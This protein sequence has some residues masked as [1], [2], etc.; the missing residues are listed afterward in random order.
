MLFEYVLVKELKSGVTKSNKNYPIVISG[1]GDRWNLFNGEHV[2]LNKAYTFGYEK[3]EDGQYKNLR[4]VIPLENIFMQKALKE[5][6]NRS[7]LKRDVLMCLSYSKDLLVGGVIQKS[8]LLTMADEIYKY[9]SEKT[10][11]LMPKE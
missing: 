7:D 2:E 8:E 4:Q 6:A 1:T 10:D 3:S 9:V 5:V 11:E